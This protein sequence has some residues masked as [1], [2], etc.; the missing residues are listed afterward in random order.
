MIRPTL[1]AVA[2]IVTL[3]LSNSQ[4]QAQNFISQTHPIP[5]TT[6]YTH[7]DAMKVLGSPAQ[8]RGNSTFPMQDTTGTSNRWDTIWERGSDAQSR[9]Y[10]RQQLN[11][12]TTANY[13][14]RYQPQYNNNAYNAAQLQQSIQQFAYALQQVRQQRLMRMQ[15]QQQYYQQPTGQPGYRFGGYY[16]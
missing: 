12:R 5:G 14:Q 9:N 10:Q 15:Q 2:A 16:R 3:T 7:A 11:Y 8:H 4:A 6:N 13:N 1:I